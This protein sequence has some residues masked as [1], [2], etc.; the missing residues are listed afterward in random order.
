MFK[1]VMATAAM[2]A[3]LVLVGNNAFAVSTSTKLSNGTLYFEAQD[4]SQVSGN[5]KLFYSVT[6]YTKTGG[7]ETS[8]QLAIWTTTRL[9]KTDA[10]KIS[11]GRTKAK[12]WGGLSKALWAPDCK[13][14]GYMVAT[15]G[16]YTTPT[17]TFC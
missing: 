7:G 12:S 3:A 14:T 1:R 13:A 17:V 4:G 2:T 11:A 16:Q 15:S 5:S 9:H 6:K 10:M 8:I